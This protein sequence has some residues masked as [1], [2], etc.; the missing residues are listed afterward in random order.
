MPEGDS[1]FS[2]RWSLIKARFSRSIEA[3]ERRS[4]SRVR[5]RSVAFGVGFTSTQFATRTISRATSTTSI[6]IQSSTA[7]C[8]RFAIGGIPRSMLSCEE[9]G[10]P[11]TGL[12]RTIRNIWISIELGLAARPTEIAFAAGK[13]RCSLRGCNIRRVH[14]M[15]RRDTSKMRPFVDAVLA[16][17]WQTASIDPQTP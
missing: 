15:R 6:G 8:G 3:G 1:D 16:P 5:R 12:R 14:S 4:A 2:T 9:D 13:G 7:G 11:G 10:C 17:I